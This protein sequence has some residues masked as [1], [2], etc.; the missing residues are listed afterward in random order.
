MI[1]P[2]E[3]PFYIDGINGMGRNEFPVLLQRVQQIEQG[4]G[5][6]IPD[7]SRIRAGDFHECSVLDVVEHFSAGRK[8]RNQ[9]IVLLSGGIFGDV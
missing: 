9:L 3:K 7:C 1:Q 6:A 8:K 2:S 5:A 4:H